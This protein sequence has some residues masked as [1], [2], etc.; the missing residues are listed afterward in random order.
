M[1]FW[2][3][4]CL[5]HS[6]RSVLVEQEQDDI[7]SNEGELFLGIMLQDYDFLPRKPVR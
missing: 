5:S 7:A 2:S 6:S 3:T 1:N 4:A